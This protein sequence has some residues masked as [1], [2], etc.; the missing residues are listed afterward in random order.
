MG[1]WF[2][3]REGGEDAEVRL[4]CFPHA[5][6]G[7]A[8]FRPWHAWLAPK[9][10]VL[11][12]V[13]PGRERRWREPPH[14]RMPDLL[15]PLFDAMVAELD[16]PYAFFGHSMGAA[17]AYAMTQRLAPTAFGPP[18][19]LVVSGRQPPHLPARR[20]PIHHLPE[21]EMLERVSALAGT[22]PVVA[23]NGELLRAFLPGMRADLELNETYV[24]AAQA[25]LSI[26]VTALVGDRDPLV[27]PADMSAW[28]ELTTGRFTLRIF[29]GDHFYLTGGRP[30]VLRAVQ[31]AVLARP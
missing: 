16:R 6:G 19:A 13:L 1:D 15:E 11:G 9:V 14:T 4:F 5:G 30:E 31:E 12:V 20:P 28:G 17:V 26:A 29:D 25:R 27:E 23:N 8:L 22:P 7:A 21:D 2:E 24:P 18:R 3:R 10:Q